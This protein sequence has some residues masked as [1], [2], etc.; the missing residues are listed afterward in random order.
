MGTKLI[1][2][3]LILGLVLIG[4]FL[5]VEPEQAYRATRAAADWLDNR[6]DLKE[7]WKTWKTFLT[8]LR[9]WS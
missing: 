5:L 6:I 7:M 3:A 2:F 4:Y 1:D 9:S 8:S